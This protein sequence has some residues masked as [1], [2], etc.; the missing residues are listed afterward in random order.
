MPLGELYLVLSPDPCNAG[1]QADD[2]N[3]AGNGASDS[4]KTPPPPS[5]SLQDARDVLW[6]DKNHAR[7]FRKIVVALISFGIFVTALFQHVP[8]QAM[9]A[10]SLSVSSVLATS[11]SDTVTD[12]SPVKFL[13]IGTIPDIFDWLNNTFVPEVFVTEDYNG[14]ALPDEGRGRIAMF[15]QVLGA[16]SFQ[17]THMQLQ[18]CKT[19][20]FLRK[21]YPSCYDAASATTDELLINFDSNTTAAW[22]IL[23]EKRASGDWL[24]FS[25]QQLL[26]TIVTLN[27]ELQGYLVT[28]LQ[29]D[30]NEGGFITPSYSTTP[31]LSNQYPSTRTIVLD[32]LVVLWFSPWMLIPAVAS[33]TIRYDR[34]HSLTSRRQVKELCRK[35]CQAIGYWS[36]PDGWMAIDV[37]RGPIVHAFYIT[38]V[39]THV[40]MTDSMFRENLEA[41]R[42]GGQVGSKTSET[43]ASV[44]QS[45]TH[46]AY[47]TV[48][49]RLL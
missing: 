49:M 24:D 39:I 32:I 5:I 31:A 2:P 26:I 35:I 10:Q 25:I 48:L 20:S 45:F 27:G 28:K 8:T 18:D 6:H 13:N 43:L 15:N 37:L 29:L 33:F 22:A 17:V 44:T 23:D 3:A 4:S 41:L 14:N 19:Q 46:I 30:F 9:Y 16:I 38:V 47:L 7:D 42:D 34:T 36:F 40:A 12:E 21:L 11:G 1:G